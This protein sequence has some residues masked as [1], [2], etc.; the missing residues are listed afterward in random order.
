MFFG[1]GDFPGWAS[2]VLEVERFRGLTGVLA[3]VY[4]GFTGFGRF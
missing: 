3:K 1:F 4:G 2:T